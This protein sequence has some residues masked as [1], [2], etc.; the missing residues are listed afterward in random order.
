MEK[1]AF[2][3]YLVEITIYS[4]DYV[5]GPQWKIWNLNES[6]AYNCPCQQIR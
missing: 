5:A 2:R 3:E 4:F 1:A 6:A